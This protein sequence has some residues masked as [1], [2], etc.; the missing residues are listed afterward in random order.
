MEYKL[1]YISRLFSKISHKRTESY[2]INRLWNKLDDTRIQFVLQQYVLRKEGQYALADVYL[3]QLKLAVE[4]DE[5]YHYDNKEAD[6]IRQSEI[7]EY[8]DVRR[9][10]CYNV[11]DGKVVDCSLEEVNQRTDDVVAY[12]KQRITELG[13]DFRP[14]K[15]ID[16]V[17][18]IQERGGLSV[19][20]D[21]SLYTIDDIAAVFGTRP[22]HRGFLRASGVAVPNKPDEVVWWPNTSHRKWDNS[23]Q[24]DG[25]TITECP[26]NES[27]RAAH[28][29]Q[30]IGSNEK[31]IVFLRYT[32]MLGLTSY[33]FMGVYQ[34]NKERSVKE[35]RC[36]WE[37]ISETYVLDNKNPEI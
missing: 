31:R 3:P 11:V 24:E 34:M 17:S 18:D 8:M 21:I 36:V 7:A 22:K 15:D 13:D 1:D 5:P 26:R 16:T 30:H 9:I 20:D 10:R 12:I 4:V 29:K 2:V 33:R 19:K 35:N 27:E 28:V 6:K 37:R 14:W 25:V 23:L 32:D